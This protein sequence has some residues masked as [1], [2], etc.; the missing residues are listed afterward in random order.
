MAN[1]V[2]PHPDERRT[3]SLS[4]FNAEFRPLTIPNA[5]TLVRLLLLVPVCWS[6]WTGDQGSWMPVVLLAIWASTDWVDGVLARALDQTSKFGKWLDPVADRLGIWGIALTLAASRAI[7]WWVLIVIVAVDLVVAVAAARVAFADELNVSWVGKART[8]VLFVAVV[9]V[10]M[11]ITVWTPALGF[12]QALLI[13][14]L[15]LHVV[16][17]VGYIANGRRYARSVPRA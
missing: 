8:A 5:I 6:I 17:A 16:A 11:G 14:G 1:A 12:G 15:A 9:L 3:T 2:D 4:A 13:V 7:G 10:V